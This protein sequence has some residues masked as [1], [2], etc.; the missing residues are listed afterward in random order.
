MNTEHKTIDENGK[1]IEPSWFERNVNLIIIG[2]V[3]ACVVSLVAQA[4]LPM[5]DDHHPPHF[6]EYENFF[7]FQAIFGFVAFVVAVF[8]GKFLRL[9]I[10]RE[11]DYYD[12]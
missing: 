8:V 2:L 6:P 1:P 5:F 10:R 12:A 7:G 9:I 11:E 3:V 4:V